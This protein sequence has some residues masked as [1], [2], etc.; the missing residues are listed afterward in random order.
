[1]VTA[2]ALHSDLPTRHHVWDLLLA[3]VVGGPVLY[4][5]SLQTPP[6]CQPWPRAQLAGAGQGAQQPWGVGQLL[7]GKAQLSQASSPTLLLHLGL[8]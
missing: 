6:W 4:S 2:A 5:G 7:P 8:W 3:A 1:M